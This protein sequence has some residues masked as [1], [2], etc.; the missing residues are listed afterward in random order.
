MG[1]HGLWRLLDSFGS[2]VQ[3]EELR[4]KRVAIDASI[5]M[6]QFRARA[7]PGE[8]VE[9]KILEGFLARILKL[10]FYGIRPVFVF[11]GVASSS[12][13]AEHQRRLMQRARNAQLF[14]KRS[15]RHILMAQVAAGTISVEELRAAAAKQGGVGGDAGAEE[16]VI[17]AAATPPQDGADAVGPLP[18]EKGAVQAADVSGHEG[19]RR[20]KRLRELTAAE[21]AG[22]ARRHSGRHRHR[23]RRVPLAPDTVSATT[24]RCFLRDAE[25]LLG[26]RSRLEACVLNNVLQH[27]STS[28]F[29]GPRHTVD[30][31]S[32]AAAPGGADSAQP[33]HPAHADTTAAVVLNSDDSCEVSDES[34][35]GYVCVGDSDGSDDSSSSECRALGSTDSDVE[36]VVVVDEADSDA[37]GVARAEGGR[38]L[39]SSPVRSPSRASATAV[40][41][42]DDL[43]RFLNALSESRC[44]PPPAAEGTAVAPSSPCAPA[45]ATAVV[46]SAAS[47]DEDAASESSGSRSLGSDSCSSSSS[48]SSGG[49]AS[50][51]ISDSEEDTDAEG[52]GDDAENTWEPFTQRFHAT[53]LLGEPAHESGTVCCPP[54][55]AATA[56]DSLR[57][58]APLTPPRADT[59]AGAGLDESDD[60]EY[61][62]VKGSCWP[63]PR[64]AATPLVS[65]AAAVRSGVGDVRDSSTALPSATVCHP[66]AAPSAPHAALHGKPGGAPPRI[67]GD[68]AV[69]VRK[70]VVPFELFSVV[71]LLDCCGVP[72]VLSPAEADAQCA[73]LARHGLVDA[74]FTE[75][76]DVLVHGAT[77]VLRGFFAQSKSV[78]AYEQAQLAACGITKTVLVALASLLGCD[79][80]EGV[81]GIGVVGA[82]EALVVS[83][84]V[85][86][87]GRPDAGSAD[88]TLHV[89]RR[90]AQLVQSPPQAWEEVDDDM[91]VLQFVLL[92]AAMKQWCTLERR[93]HF[94]ETHAVDAFYDA[95]VDADTTPFEWLPP[96]WQ[97]IRVFAGVRGALSSTWLVQRYELARKEC[98]RREE[99]A[100]RAAAAQVAGQRRLTEFGVQQRMRETWA[101]QKQPP[102]HAA[103]L[104]Q[105]RAVQHA[106]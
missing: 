87:K 72:Y 45:A 82:L 92:R 53:Q 8:D 66:A 23:R 15:A 2:V 68:G 47:T 60:G 6:A 5:W 42:G 62:P 19:P 90:W 94:P 85:P 49:G 103:V 77:T 99:E 54:G 50:T 83:W 70:A 4:D 86:E 100:S 56:T 104:A 33:A 88:L 37:C 78:V 48:S 52:D 16:D 30:T 38:S 28:L 10:L 46:S 71:E 11:D 7:A 73:F 95:V 96:D 44:T 105:L 35:N 3:P 79:Y 39:A 27:T 43:T 51:S 32:A 31:T 20:G 34:D 40:L 24:T 29:M 59:A 61:T 69:R 101:L 97:R 98:L 13:G 21:T 26:D 93:P 75:D 64:S 36:E 91:S 57:A 76:S 65:T 84:G 1:V 74:V 55:T 18:L 89:L 81:C 9:H 17:R 63:A 41:H 25:A 106:H 14:L 22:R 102:R 12:K 80:T 67:V 58:A